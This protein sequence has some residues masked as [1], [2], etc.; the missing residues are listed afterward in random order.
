MNYAKDLIKL[1]KAEIG[2]KEKKSPEYEDDKTKNAGFNNYT[3]YGRDL[4]AWIGSPYMDGVYWC[5]MF[6]DWLFVKAFGIDQA[7]KLLG[8]WSAYCPTSAYY[9]KQMNSYYYS[10]PQKGDVIYFLDSYGEQGHTGVVVDVDDI[11]VYTVEGNTAPDSGVIDNGGGVYN[12]KYSRNYSRIDGYGRP[13]YDEEVIEP[14]LV[15]DGLD[16]SKVYDYNFYIKKYADIKAVLEPDGKPNK[17]GV[18]NHFLSHGM[19]EGRQA[20]EAFIIGIYKYNYSDLRD[21]FK[22]DLP[23]YYQHYI[24]N[25]IREKRVANYHV[26]PYSIYD[27]VDYS[28]VYD[29]KFYQEKYPDLKKAYGDNF[30]KYIMHFVKWGMQA[31]EHRQASKNFNPACYRANYADLENKFGNDW[32][33]YY[34]HY[35]GYGQREKRVADKYLKEPETTY[36]YKDGDS[37]EKIAAKYNLTVDKLL[38]LNGITF[39]DGQKIKVRA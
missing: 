29:G 17:V 5:D 14:D 34:M 20:N 31:R 11:Y 30:D 3:K 6:V 19:K 2:Y 1:A 38:E 33:A 16:Y 24:K 36:T 23:K 9:F 4:A 8:G 22:E 27:G 35:I 26:V 39:K 25:G 12:K 13:K 37:I 21:A 28:A 7:K 32:P 15:V 18:F 10:N